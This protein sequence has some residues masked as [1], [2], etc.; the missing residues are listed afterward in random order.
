MKKILALGLLTASFTSLAGTTGDIVLT[1]VVNPLV[2]IAVS[3]ESTASNLD[4]HTTQTDLLVGTTVETS[5]TQTGYQILI[6]S[7][8]SGFLVHNSGADS[9]SYT[10]KYGG[11]SVALSTTPQVAINNSTGGVSVQNR[12]VQISYTGVPQSSLVAGTYSDTVTLTI[13]A[14]P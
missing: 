14:N 3:S 8:N 7:A 4:L 9:L 12:D 13:Q 2:D 5:N 6:S 1:G 10:L 11:N